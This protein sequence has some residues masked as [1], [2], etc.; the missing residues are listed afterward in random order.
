[1]KNKEVI[2]FS[3]YFD[4]VDG[5]DLVVPLFGSIPR[6]N[7]ILHQKGMSFVLSEKVIFE[8]LSLLTF[9]TETKRKRTHLVNPMINKKPSPINIKEHERMKAILERYLSLRRDY[10]EGILK[11]DPGWCFEYYYQHNLSNDE[12]FWKSQGCCEDPS[13]I[14]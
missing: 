6:Y 5:S 10:K 13:N 1:M 14:D 12:D 8:A 7:V 11:E 3:N 4:F 9:K 2:N